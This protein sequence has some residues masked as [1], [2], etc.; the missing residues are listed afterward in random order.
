MKNIPN[1]YANSI[2]SST[3]KNTLESLC[4]ENSKVFNPTNVAELQELQ[5]AVVQLTNYVDDDGGYNDENLKRYISTFFS[6]YNYFDKKHSP[7]N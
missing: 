3:G 7:Q 5:N 4:E 6:V 2:D 1:L